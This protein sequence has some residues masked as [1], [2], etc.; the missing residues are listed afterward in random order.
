MDKT[1]PAGLSN[2]MF[3]LLG[4]GVVL[5][6][7]VGSGRE[8]T[9]PFQGLHSWGRADGARFAR[10]HVVYGLGYTGGVMTEA[11]GNP[12]PQPP[13]RYVNHPQLSSLL[14]SAHMWAF[15]PHEWVL[16]GYWILMSVLTVMAFL[17]LLRPL[18]GG[19]GAILGGLFWSIFPITAYFGTGGPCLLMGLLGVLFYLRLVGEFG[20]VTGRRRKWL[21]VG[22]I[23]TNFLCLQFNWTGGF[24]CLALVVH[25][26][27]RCILRRQWP[28]LP[29]A[30]VL[31]VVPA[32]SASVTLA[33]MLH[34]F[35]WDFWRVID[36]FLWR[37]S[38]GEMAA[39]MQTFD[40]RKWFTTF[41]EY[42]KTNFT[43]YILVLAT[44]GVHIHMA[45]RLIAHLIAHVNAEKPVK[46]AVLFVGSPQLILLVLPGVLQLLVFRG[47]L[48]K[49]QYWELPLGPFVALGCTLCI[50]ALYDLLRGVGK[51][52]AMVVIGVV[53]AVLAVP[54]VQGANHYFDI[55]WQHDD[56]I[57]LWKKLNELIP[58]DKALW[59]FD[60]DLDGVVVTQSEAK[61]EVIRAEPAWYIDRPVRWVLPK[62]EA[63]TIYRE[64]GGIQMKYMRAIN[65]LNRDISYGRIS[66]D[67]V[68]AR[69]TQA[70]NNYQSA[71]RAL[72][73]RDLPKMLAEIKS[74]KD[75][76]PI[77][78][79]PF[80]LHF[81][82]R[83]AGMAIDLSIYGDLLNDELSRQFALVY[84]APSRQG[85]STEDGRFL[86]VG[87]R[88]YYVYDVTKGPE[89][90]TATPR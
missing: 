45:R 66:R 1:T 63:E 8:I 2:R 34:G 9:R 77:Y 52:L 46:L 11:V 49:H 90:S 6:T 58:P 38:K 48:W 86:K 18:L 57:A 31:L 80:P 12:P 47:T 50:L 64:V 75:E 29:M 4:A 28:T 82:D 23:A 17:A 26:V 65:A 14:L 41:W 22:L 37:A 61:G 40:W 59:V 51:P 56:R 5:V 81:I 30:I 19:A 39:T 53:V 10:A 25:Y 16:R 35:G 60:P 84:Y 89:E 7:L 87:M 54:C 21:W 72:V 78:L 79:M 85:E 67:V 62:G 20:E 70:A 24:Y 36:L 55:R 68:R 33:I 3:W 15:G 13:K 73:M 76:A 32:L 74:R 88:A 69:K 42:A 83:K 71:T 43:I 27:C 44:I